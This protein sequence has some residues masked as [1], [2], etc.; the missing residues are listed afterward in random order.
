MLKKLKQ[1]FINRKNRTNLYCTSDYWD[2]KADQ[3]TESAVSMWPNTTLNKYYH[4]ELLEILFSFN[5]NFNNLKVLDLGCGTGRL[6]RW[7]ADK[8]AQVKGIDFS[9]K[10]IDIAKL[11]NENYNI[12]YEVNSIFD[13]NEDTNYDFIYIGGVFTVACKDKDQ[14]IISLNKLKSLLSQGGSVFFSEPIHTG[15]LSRVLSLSIKD[16]IKIMKH[17][18][19]KISFTKSIHFWPF[20]LLL[21]YYPLPAFITTPIFYLGKF[22]LKLPFFSRFGDYWCIL[23][24]I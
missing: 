9:K 3:Y 15:F 7:F 14:L 23:A 19:F 4:I 20:R 1:L 21:C 16:F 17:Q 6:S 24:S 18:G 8:G 5:L 22:L 2:S 11:L 10:S 13:L 12:K